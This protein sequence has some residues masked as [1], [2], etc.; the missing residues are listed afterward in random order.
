MLACNNQEVQRYQKEV[1]KCRK[2]VEYFLCTY[3]HIY[4][5]T[6]SKWMPFTL[7]PAQQ[8]ALRTIVAHRLTVILKAR[9]LG[10]TWLVLGYALWLML[11]FPQ[12]TILFFSR[13][14][15]EA[16]DLLKKRL[17]GLYERLPA[18][19]K[20]KAFITDNDH[21]WHWSNGSRVLAFPTTGGDSYSATLVI[22][23][24]A[25]LVADLASLMASVKPTIDGGGRMVLVSRVDKGRP[26]SPFKRIYLA[27]RK[28][29]I[30]WE[31]VF[32]PWSAHPD[33]DST[34][35]EVQKADILHRTAALDELHEQYPATDA[36]ALL[37]RTLDKRIAP[38]WLYQCYQE[39]S[40]LLPVPAGC[41]ALPELEIYALPQPGRH[42]VIGADPAEGN[43]TSDDSALTILDRDSGAEVASLAGKFQPSTLAAHVDALGTWYNGA[44][45][46]VERNNHGH[47]VLLGLREHS[48]LIRLLGHDN[49][50]GWLSNS[51]GKALLYDTTADAFRE[52]ATQ[53]HSFAT[54][55]Q[56]ASIEGATLRA[57]EGEADDRADSYALACAACRFRPPEPY[58]GPLVYWPP[59]PFGSDPATD[60]WGD[61]WGN[62][63]GPG[64]KPGEPIW[65]H[66]FRDLNID[67]DGDWEEPQ[68]L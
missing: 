61:L 20:V 59:V 24:E 28:K 12:A 56:L 34:W 66:V 19:L 51:K 38:D 2:S 44:Q 8:Q 16:V 58:R 35:Y 5:A 41:P 60:Q 40:P 14:D 39:Q 29:Q 4:D 63:Y 43:P 23:D 54:F 30:G 13:R 53:L 52:Q 18:W 31:A 3:C 36:E 21:E 65:L 42:Y 48:R 64:P 27:A 50:E 22:V 46:L 15:E 17:R 62:Q 45:V 7:W 68:L 32:L 9:Q 1:H 57:P 10:L 6:S 25:D 33:R 26:R 47:A 67:P 49:R 37:P 55:T 11:F